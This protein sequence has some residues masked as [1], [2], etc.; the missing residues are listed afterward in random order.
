MRA[1][2]SAAAVCFGGVRGGSGGLYPN[3]AAPLESELCRLH[4]SKRNFNDCFVLYIFVFV[5]LFV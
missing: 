2:P 4:V 1:R 3:D 5:V